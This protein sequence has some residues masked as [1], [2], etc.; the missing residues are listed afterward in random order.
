MPLHH[1][2]CLLCCHTHASYNYWINPKLL[3]DHGAPA[4]RLNIYITMIEDL[5][6]REKFAKK[7]GA[8][9]AVIDVY[10]IQRDR[11]SLLLYKAKLVPQTEEWWYAENALNAGNSRWKN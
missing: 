2:V 4:D 1:S 9:T 7:V 11:Q 5:C 3:Y 6:E 8:H 10:A